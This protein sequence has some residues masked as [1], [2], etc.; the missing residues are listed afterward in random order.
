MEQIKKVKELFFENP[1]KEFYLREIG[2][3]TNVPITSTK[4]ILNKLKNEGLTTKLKI[5]PYPKYRANTESFYYMYHKK[6][7]L[8]EKI[9]ESG[10]IAYL[11]KELSPALIILFGS[12]AKGEYNFKS[13]IDLFVQSEENKINLAKYEKI[14]KHKI[15]V[16][17]DKSIHNLSQ[18]LANNVL[19]GEKLYGF[20]RLKW[21][22]E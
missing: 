2:K 19:N 7:N 6:N 10:L 9:Y 20:I 18:E 11:V 1:S 15:N 3:A 17:F 5:K 4:R 22:K 8:I 14:L 12:C 16:F 13:D 21:I